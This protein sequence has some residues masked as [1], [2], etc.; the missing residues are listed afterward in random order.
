MGKVDFSNLFFTLNGQSF[1]TLDE[2]KKAG[3]AT[4]NYGLFTNAIIDFVIVAFAIFIIVKAANKVQKPAVVAA[5]TKECPEC[6]SAIPLK[7]KKCAHC[8]SPQP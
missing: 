8:L 5:T 2:A 7:A 4:V 3:V 6:L 1:A